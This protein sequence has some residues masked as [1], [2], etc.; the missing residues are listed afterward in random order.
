MRSCGKQTRESECEEVSIVSEREEALTARRLVANLVAE[1][2]QA[3]VESHL[4][5]GIV[6]AQFSSCEEPCGAPS[7]KARL[8]KGDDEAAVVSLSDVQTVSRQ[9]HK[10][11]DQQE[12]IIKHAVLVQVP[13]S[14][15]HR[16]L[17]YFQS[18]TELKAA[19]SAGFYRGVE[20][21]DGFKN[22]AL[23]VL[24]DLPE[25]M[26]KSF[27]L[28][29]QVLWTKPMIRRVYC[30][31]RRV[32]T[33]QTLVERCL[34]AYP[35]IK[36]TTIRILAYPN[37]L[38]D[39]LVGLLSAHGVKMC[40]VQGEYQHVLYVTR[41]VFHAGKDK[42]YKRLWFA[43]READSSTVFNS[44]DVVQALR[45]ERGQ[46]ASTICRASCKM[47]ELISRGHVEV[48]QGSTLAVD[49]GSAPGGWTLVLARAGATVW[50]ID[51]AVLRIPE[52]TPNVHYYSC[53][54]E[55]AVERLQGDLAGRKLNLVV[56]D[57]NLLPPEAWSV[58]VQ[59]FM[60]LCSPGCRVVMTCK[61]DRHKDLKRQCKIAAELMSKVCSDVFQ[62]HEQGFYQFGNCI[63][64][65]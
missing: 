55:E 34:S 15:A 19:T 46:S 7:K 65:G 1:S 3:V 64:F 42:R 13:Q 36:D 44:E 5:E 10:D 48:S 2:I 6:A 27:V 62:E 28:R 43:L 12:E 37:T 20:V 33:I 16:F 60:A 31:E 57:A 24:H 51:P 54:A 35:G 41:V 21:L 39:E 52:D 32:R 8:E 9:G 11:G 22:D 38:E 45:E 59:P 26:V 58:L 4:T 29:D 23:I 40:A 18:C 50:S 47:E 61:C 49:I 14:L 30:V 25:E 56:C 63:C 53:K 17:E